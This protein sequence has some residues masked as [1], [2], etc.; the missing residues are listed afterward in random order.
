M[1]IDPLAIDWLG[2]GWLLLLAFSAAVLLGAALRRPCRRWFGTECAFQLWL[3]PPL[4][5]LASQLPHPASAP[6]GALPSVV[7][8]MASIAAA[9]PARAATASALDWRDVAMLLWLVGTIAALLLAAA[10]QW[11]YRRRLVG[12]TPMP[13]V[14]IGWPVLRA[15]GVDVGPALVGAWRTRQPA[16][17]VATAGGA[18]ARRWSAPCSGSTRW[19]GGRWPRCATTRNWPATRLCC[20]STAASDAGMRMRC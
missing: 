10:A 18:C 7:Y 19:R 2:R 20:A 8:A 5:M 12:A 15:A 9:L 3:L 11:R 13:D 4:A 6:M 17:A 16:P 1:R 14:A